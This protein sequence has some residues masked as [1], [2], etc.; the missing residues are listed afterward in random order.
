MD[1]GPAGAKWVRRQIHVNDLVPSAKSCRRVM[2]ADSFGATGSMVPTKIEMVAIQIPQASGQRSTGDVCYHCWKE[3]L[4]A[5]QGVSR[6]RSLDHDIGI[7]WCELWN[8]SD[9]A[10]G[11]VWRI[12]TLQLPTLLNAENKRRSKCFCC[13]FF[14]CN[15]AWAAMCGS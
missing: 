9:A 1:I 15:V 3:M 10:E 2:E 13:I 14:C 4:A 8:R 7:K 6:W 11:R 12:L 5:I